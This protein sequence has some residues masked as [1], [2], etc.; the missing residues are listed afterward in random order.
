MALKKANKPVN[1]L[2]NSR[3][4]W[5]AFAFVEN[6]QSFN[7]IRISETHHSIEDKML[8]I[9]IKNISLFRIGAGKKLTQ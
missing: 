3:H 5:K 8:C 4:K 1:R 6:L 2:S 7:I 9:S